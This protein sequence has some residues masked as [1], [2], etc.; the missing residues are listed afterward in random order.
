MDPAFNLLYI[1]FLNCTLAFLNYMQYIYISIS[2]CIRMYVSSCIDTI[3]KYIT[4]NQLC[5]IYVIPSRQC[6]FCIS[7]CRKN[8]FYFCPHFTHTGA[9]DTF[10]QMLELQDASRHPSQESLTGADAGHLHPGHAYHNGHHRRS[11][12]LR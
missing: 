9:L 6:N 12:S 8:R 11:P 5:I 4:L 1:H 2:D 3:V 7:C 10:R